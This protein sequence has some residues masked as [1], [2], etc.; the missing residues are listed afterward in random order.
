MNNWRW[1]KIAIANNKSVFNKQASKQ[2]ETL[3]KFEKT[4]YHLFYLFVLPF[5]GRYAVL[6]CMS[7]VN[8]PLLG[9]ARFEESEAVDDVT[10]GTHSN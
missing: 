1:D 10:V 3:R 5:T 8:P 6:C 7:N 2:V 9:S 4:C